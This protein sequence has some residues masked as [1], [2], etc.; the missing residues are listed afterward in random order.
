[1]K[2]N[3]S[4]SISLCMIVK[5]EEDV[6]ERCLM[7]V[8][9]LVDE[10]IIVD[11]GSSDCTKEIISA[12]T[13]FIFDFNWIDDFSAARNFA[14]S[15]A[16]KDYILW[17]DADDIITEENIINFLTLKQ[18]L[19]RDVD[20]V[21]MAYHLAFDQDG[22][23]SFSS[24]RNRLVK[25]EKQFKWHGFVHEYLEVNG[26]TLYSDI[27]IEHRKEN[28]HN[29]RNLVIYEKALKAERLFSPRDQYYYANECKDHGMYEKA[30]E[31]YQKFLNSKEGWVE[32]NIE[33]C[34]RMADCYIH[35]KNWNE[36]I[37]C[38]INS[39]HYDAPRGENCCRLGFLY[40]QESKFSQAIS[41]YKL[42]TVVDSSRLKSPFINHA[43]HTWLPHLQLCLCYSK[44]GEFK[45]AKE[46]ND[47]AAQYAPNNPCVKH[48][49]AFFKSI[50]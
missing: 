4:I 41:W 19:T 16:T 27:A 11:T 42:A 12:Y 20:A 33:A 24:W 48:N 32:D 13:D 15:K 31:W 38:C 14:F 40:L 45:V 26:N 36:A 25:R 50:I 8:K 28:I 35:L 46:H 6:I 34:G 23:A 9:S 47:L 5:N 1:M 39:F 7:S 44:L 10:I 2:K 21:S 37:N 17:L 43:C 49:Q 18:A 30:I 3:K 22:N 29:A